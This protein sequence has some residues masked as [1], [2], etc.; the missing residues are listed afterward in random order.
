MHRKILLDI[1]LANISDEK[2]LVERGTFN[3]N[4]NAYMNLNDIKN[5]NY[6]LLINWLNDLER[7]DFLDLTSLRGDTEQ[8]RIMSMT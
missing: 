8:E 2:N 3:Y 1:S 5:S 6:Q 7:N 4:A